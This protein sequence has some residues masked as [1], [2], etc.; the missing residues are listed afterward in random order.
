M[1]RF[2]PQLLCHTRCSDANSDL[3]SKDDRQQY[4]RQEYA[5]KGRGAMNDFHLMA[6]SLNGGCEQ[7]SGHSDPHKSYSDARNQD[8]RT[9]S[10]SSEMLVWPAAAATSDGVMLLLQRGDQ[11]RERR[12]VE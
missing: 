9:E 12:G 4:D 6:S 8:S 7:C 2:N 3:S 5:K 10:K 1:V 11:K